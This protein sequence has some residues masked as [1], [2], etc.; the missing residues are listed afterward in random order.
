MDAPFSP[1]SSSTALMFF[2]F[3]DLPL[4]VAKQ[5]FVGKSY[6]LRMSNQPPCWKTHVGE[7]STCHISNVQNFS[8]DD[9]LKNFLCHKQNVLFFAFSFVF[10]EKVILGNVHNSC[11]SD[12]SNGRCVKIFYSSDVLPNSRMAA[13]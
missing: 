8:C 11:V 9:F 3:T 6:N 2:T 1:G 12:S 5:V 7:L 10:C 4:S 13:M